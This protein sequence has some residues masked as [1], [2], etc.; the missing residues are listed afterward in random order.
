MS[1]ACFAV[2]AAADPGV[3]P[4]LLE[5]FA[6]RGLVPS[7]VHSRTVGELM[8]VDLQVDGL[9]RGQAEVVAEQLRAN[10]MVER[11]LLADMQAL[12]Q[13]EAAA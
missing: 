9:D 6:K 7:H 5:A 10:V 2:R 1:T 13:T 3:L 12:G 4:R 11:V 8:T